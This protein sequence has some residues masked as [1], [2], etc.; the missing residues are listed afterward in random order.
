M[1]VNTLQ[2]LLNGYSM[3]YPT[4]ELNS[5]ANV[6]SYKYLLRNELIVETQPDKRNPGFSITERG[7]VYVEFIKNIPLPTPHW[8]VEL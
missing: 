1:N 3:A 5:P 8:K 7:T 4:V 2:I 6:E